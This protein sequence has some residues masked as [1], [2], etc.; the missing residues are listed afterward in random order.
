MSHASRNIEDIGTEGDLNI[1]S[2]IQEISEEKI[3]VC[4]LETVLV[5][6]Y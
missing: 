4:G 6:F 1:G 5:I 3:L 2:L